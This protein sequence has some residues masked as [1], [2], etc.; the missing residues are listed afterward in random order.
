MPLREP[1]DERAGVRVDERD[2][3]G[4]FERDRHLVREFIPASLQDL[5]LHHA[6]LRQ[7]RKPVLSHEQTNECCQQIVGASTVRAKAPYA[8]A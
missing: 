5:T 7:R 1:A 4:E 3:E 2:S 6:G 8:C